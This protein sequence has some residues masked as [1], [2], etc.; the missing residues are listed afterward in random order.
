MSMTRRFFC[1]WPFSY[2]IVG[3]VNPLEI[4]TWIL[5]NHCFANEAV[6]VMADEW[7]K[8]YGCNHSRYS[9]I[10]QGLVEFAGDHWAWLLSGHSG[11]KLYCCQPPVLLGCL[12]SYRRLFLLLHNRAAW[13]Q[14]S[15]TW[16]GWTAGHGLVPILQALHIV[17]P[18]RFSSTSRRNGHLNT[19]P[20]ASLPSGVHGGIPRRRLLSLKGQC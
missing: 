9:H 16:E 20:R 10:V 7:E 15:T 14:P 11:V 8:V 12:R 6:D 4:A 18:C 19:A 17:M 13:C 1:K 3:V 5:R 2:R